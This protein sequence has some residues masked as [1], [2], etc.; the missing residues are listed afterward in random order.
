MYKAVRLPRAVHMLRKELRR[1]WFSAVTD[2][3][4]LCKQEVKRKAD[5]STAW[6]SVKDIWPSTHT[7]PLSRNWETYWFQAFM[8]ISVQSLTGHLANTGHT[9]QRTQTLQIQPEKPL[10]KQQQQILKR[11]KNLIFGLAT[12]HFFSSP[13]SI[14]YSH[15][16]MKNFKYREELKKVYNSHIFTTQN[17]QLALYCIFITYLSIPLSTHQYTS[18]PLHFFIVHFIASCR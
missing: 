12:K 1:P 11:E 10:G 3:E 7:D 13:Q 5:L 9:Q 2:L 17:L 14:L 6:L 16:N 15:F 4:A 8:Q 18:F